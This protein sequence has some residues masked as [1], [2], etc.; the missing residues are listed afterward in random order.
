MF[1]TVLSHS[2]DVNAVQRK[3]VDRWIWSS[4][5]KKPGDTA[6]DFGCIARAL[7]TTWNERHVPFLD[8]M[9]DLWRGLC[10]PESRPLS[11]SWIVI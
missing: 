7:G 8:A 4:G 5:S 3:M 11:T 10:Q 2:I 9:V 6:R 1:Q